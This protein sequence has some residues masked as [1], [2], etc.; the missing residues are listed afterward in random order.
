MRKR[1]AV[2]GATRIRRVP[3]PHPWRFSQAKVGG[4]VYWAEG[5]AH[6]RK[7]TGLCWT[8]GQRGRKEG[9]EE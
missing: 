3:Y 6:A 8:R 5:T 1:Q 2:G 7:H 9:R 4:R